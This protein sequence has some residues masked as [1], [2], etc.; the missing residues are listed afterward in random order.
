M[1]R[2][3][4]FNVVGT[5][6]IAPGQSI[7]TLAIGGDAQAD[8]LLIEVDATEADRID[9]AGTLDVSGMNLEITNLA[10]PTQNTYII[11]SYGN[12]TGT[13]ASIT[14]IPNDYEILY[15]YD[16]SGSSNHIVLAKINNAPVIT[17][18]SDQSDTT[19]DVI[20][21]ATSASDS[22]GDSLTFSASNL[23]SGLTI[24][25]S[26]GL[27]SGTLADD[28]SDASPYSVTITVIDDGDPTKSAQTSFT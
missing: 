11:A 8:T 22:D 17:A 25:S 13:F 9:V 6:T 16:N 19:K 4:Y 3:N 14:G 24:A 7:G 1:D 5:G 12:L 10:T 26:T 20:N 18:I 27:I 28:A 23:P 15:S 21:L 2:K